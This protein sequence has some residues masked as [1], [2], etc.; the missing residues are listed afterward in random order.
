M[1]DSERTGGSDEI[2]FYLPDEAP[3]GVLANYYPSPVE[4]DGVTYKSAEHAFQ[5]FKAARK[6]VAQWIA[7]APDAF[8]AA[9]IGDNLPAHEIVPRWKERREELMRPILKA[10]FAQ[11]EALRELLLGTKDAEI[12]E[13]V[14]EDNETNRFWSKVD[15]VGA[16]VLGKLLMELRAQMAETASSA[17]RGT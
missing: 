4:L 5:A 6:E 14:H 12:S 11:N 10:K 16:N 13:W 9:A 3:Y 8:L 17:L 15:G 2:R 1:P 7:A